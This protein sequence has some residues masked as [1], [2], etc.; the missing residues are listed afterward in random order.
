M[1]KESLS[2]RKK[3]KKTLRWE[4]GMKR[5][6]RAEVAGGGE[7]KWRPIFPPISVFLSS[8]LNHLPLESL[9]SFLPLFLSPLFVFS[10]TPTSRSSLEPLS[11]LSLPT[12]PVILLS[13]MLPVR[14]LF[15]LRLGFANQWILFFFFFEFRVECWEVVFEFADLFSGLCHVDIS[16]LWKFVFFMEIEIAARGR[17][18]FM[19]RFDWIVLGLVKISYFY[20]LMRKCSRCNI[21]IIWVLF[22]LLL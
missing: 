20:W 11:S 15:P 6:G 16:D 1:I 21:A 12:I 3:K 4:K 9:I 17:E 14:I 8:L 7:I 18:N 10:L 19:Y 2:E 13:T 5:A 22:V